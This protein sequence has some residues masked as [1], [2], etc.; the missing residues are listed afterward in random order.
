MVK[1]F[2]ENRKK[3]IVE[4]LSLLTESEKLYII[5]RLQGLVEDRAQAVAPEGDVRK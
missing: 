5:E 2:S 1:D 4:K 3:E